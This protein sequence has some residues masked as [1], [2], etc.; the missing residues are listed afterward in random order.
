MGAVIIAQRGILIAV[1]KGQ[2]LVRVRSGFSVL[3]LFNAVCGNKAK[4]LGSGFSG[5]TGILA[6]D[7]VNILIFFGG[8]SSHDSVYPRIKTLLY[9]TWKYKKNQPHLDGKAFDSG[10]EAVISHF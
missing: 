1:G 4:L 8:F 5:Q 2:N 3:D 7:V 9:Y 6:A 10:I